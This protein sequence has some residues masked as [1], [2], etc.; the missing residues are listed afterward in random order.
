MLAYMDIQYSYYVKKR[1]VKFMYN[2]DD[3]FGMPR[4]VIKKESLCQLLGRSEVLLENYKAINKI[5]DEEI[6]VVC[7]KYNIKVSGDNLCVKYYSNQS[8][9]VGGIIY[10]VSI[11]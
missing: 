11:L 8:M 5:T 10:E 3:K 4:D 2:V 6:V 9:I 7:H 1:F